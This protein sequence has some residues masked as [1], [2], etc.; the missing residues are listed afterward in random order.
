MALLPPEAMTADES[1]ET[2]LDFES[3]DDVGLR[4]LDAWLRNVKGQAPQMS[5]S[6]VSHNPS[7]RLEANDLEDEDYVSD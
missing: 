1:G 3:L 4:K 7:V 2:E 5:P 6:H